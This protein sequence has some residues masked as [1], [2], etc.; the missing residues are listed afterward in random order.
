MT[1]EAQANEVLRINKELN[2]EPSILGLDKPSSVGDVFRRIIAQPHVFGEQHVAL[3]RFLNEQFPHI[4]DAVGVSNEAH[5][6][7]KRSA[8]NRATNH[9]HIDPAA[10]QSAHLQ[11]L[12]EGAHAAIDWLLDSP[13]TEGQRAAITAIGGLVDKARAALPA[14][15]KRFFTDVYQPYVMKNYDSLDEAAVRKLYEEHG[16]SATRWDPV[17][18]GLHDSHEFVAQ[19]FNERLFRQHLNGIPH[20][21]GGSVLKQAWSWFKT[22]LGIKPGTALEG[23]FDALQTLGEESKDTTGGRKGQSRGAGAVP[24]EEN[25]PAAKDVIWVA[26][27][28]FHDMAD[29]RGDRTFKEKINAMANRVAN[30]S[31]PRTMAADKDAGN[32]GV[33]YAASGIASPII[34]RSL[35]TQVLGKHWSDLPFINKLGAVL[36]QDRLNAI[37][38]TH[39]ENDEVEL[40]QGVK[41]VWEQ[42][43]SP[44]HTKEEFDK[45]LADPEIQAA[46]ARHKELLE[47]QVTKRHV[48]LGGRLARSGEESGAFINL[49]AMHEADMDPLAEE[50]EK[51]TGNALEEIKAQIYGARKGDQTNPLVRGSAFNKK[52]K[53]TAAGYDF[54]YRNIAE[55]MVKANYEEFNKQKYYRTLM[56]KGL[57]IPERPGVPA[58]LIGGKPAGK[59]VISI[60]ATRWGARRQI[61]LW[62]REDLLPEMRQALN[63]NGKVREGAESLLAKSLVDYQL[64]GPTD[65]L[66]HLSNLFG[67]VS[68]TLGSGSLA[69]D[70]V[71]QIRGPRELDAIVR[72]VLALKDA[73]FDSP[74]VQKELADMAEI[75]SGRGQVT[76]QGWLSRAIPTAKIINVVD[77][78]ARLARNRLF[79]NLVEQGLAEDTEENR[80]EFNNKLGQYNSRLQR[81]WIVTLK[82]WHI[83]DFVVAGRAFNRLA[84]ER[85][86]LDPGLR[87]KNPVAAAKMRAVL[88]VGRV[89]TL[90]TLPIVLNCILNGNPFGRPGTPL[91]AVDLGTD[92]KKGRHRTI[93]MADAITRR[94]MRNVGLE[95]AWK[96][97]NQQKKTE[98]VLQD[99]FGDMVRGAVSSFVGPAPRAVANAVTGHDVVTGYQ[100]ADNPD[101]LGSRLM[102]MLREGNPVWSATSRAKENESSFFSEIGRPFTRFTGAGEAR[103]PSL[104]EREANTPGFDKMNVAQRVALQKQLTQGR[105]PISDKQRMSLDEAE[106]RRKALVEQETRKGLSEENQTF[107]KKNKLTLPGFEEYLGPARA[108]VYLVPKERERLMGIMH[109]EYDRILNEF[110]GRV[111]KQP[112]QELKQALL[113]KALAT[114]RVRGRIRMGK[115]I[116]Q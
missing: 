49:I 105:T 2:R 53:G 35:A 37:R 104:F 3:A 86:I 54:N 108:R 47:G 65:V 38:Q 13:K 87:A 27:N 83:S 109:E 52:A 21:A 9:V 61:N 110:K 76:H 30:I 106:A 50:G 59:V 51:K 36:T 15:V 57:A 98:D 72:V 73:Y 91:G 17:L 95:A 77:R 74:E 5:P 99:A 23:T 64:I 29:A 42:T 81:D 8:Y 79:D 96:G 93:D 101:K 6:T 39:I 63:L 18:Y 16:L 71:R 111:E 46:I 4:L 97:L 24:S 114:A 90:M 31:M 102:A 28:I 26:D 44:I 100:T 14:K 34:A 32:A 1:T 69:Y 55:R 11:A 116:G 41:N 66:V 48:A 78:A 88:L 67:G 68:G 75:G 19:V 103:N 84:L 58:P 94:G 62:V 92:D 12:H 70:F 82:N 56:A 89:S 10:G 7:L 45:A 80:R 115:T 113:D 20:E 60:G 25:E 33:R 43:D 112:T 107:L 22:A 40:A 85:L